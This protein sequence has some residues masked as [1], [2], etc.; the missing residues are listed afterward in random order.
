MS[1]LSNAGAGL[2]PAWEALPA[3]EAVSEAHW[4]SWNEAEPS[5]MRFLRMPRQ[6]PCG[7]GT[8]SWPLM[9]LR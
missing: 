5:P 9:L 3:P 7:A 6:P 1:V 4:G 2:K 8:S